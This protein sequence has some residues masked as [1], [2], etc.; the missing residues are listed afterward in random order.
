MKA[1]VS[2][3]VLSVGEGVSADLTLV[4][5]GLGKGEGRVIRVRR[6]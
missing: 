4:H 2:S 5:T 1:H 6:G 3:H